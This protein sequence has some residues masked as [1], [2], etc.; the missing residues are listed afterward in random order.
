M[1]KIAIHKAGG[2]ERLTLEEHSDPVA[3]SGE[4]LVEVEA[5][6]VNFADCIVRMGL[7][8]SAKEYVGWPITPGFEVAGRNAA[9]GEKVIAVTRFG[10]YASHLVIPS[11]QVF[12][13]P[14]GWSY[15]QGACFPT[16]FLTAWYA[17]S[18][19]AAVRTGQAVLI[20]S[21]AGGVG[22]ALLQLARRDGVMAVGIV[23]APH[24]VETALSLGAAAVVDRSS[25]K[26]WPAVEGY[27]PDGFHAVFE[28]SGVATLKESYRHLRPTGRVVVFGHATML[29]RGGGRGRPNWLALGWNF[30]R[31]PR[32]NPLFMTNDNKSVM[33]FNLSYLFDQAEVLER[34]MAELLDAVGR[35]EITPPEFK[36]YPL[37][38][39]ADA[40][41]DLESG[42]TTGK[43]A[44]IP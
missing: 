32:F 11:H 7:Y 23:G 41:R 35:G 16:V 4:V 21:A 33:A 43:L 27:A 3:G 19:C 5:I 31:M 42:S 39:V 10:G 44:L 26:L 9:T 34:A 12:P 8:E 37:D 38:R 2:Y 1:R 36:R 25:E 18:H 17:Y 15:E 30:L 28:S 13:L 14:N 22:S 24:K 40:H 20:H 6:G 29:P